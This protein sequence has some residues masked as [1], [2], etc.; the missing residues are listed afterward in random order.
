M[1]TRSIAL[2]VIGT[3]LFS[4][5]SAA[6]VAW[7]LARPA[8]RVAVE[9]AE[10]AG[11]IDG[12]AWGD[13]VARI[14]ALEARGAPLRAAPVEPV[15]AAAPESERV[16]YRADD[17]PDESLEARLRRLERIEA[18]RQE[19]REVERAEDEARDAERRERELERAREA[20]ALILDPLSAD[21]LKVQA[22]LELRRADDGWND[23]IVAEMI[24][25]GTTATD[26]ELREEI[27]AGAD[28]RNRDTALVAPM[29]HALAS[30]PAAGVREEAADSLG[31]YLDEPG[32]RAAL[33]VAAESD[34]DQ[35]VREE[36][37][38]S[39]YGRR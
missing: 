23:D 24:R 15:R 30:D 1:N 35:D 39:L 22:W 31:N 4:S 20:Q 10:P 3:W 26:A 5:A 37:Y 38:D 9:V 19:A 18:E 28:A 27:W 36:A 6:A 13:L 11:A 7:L 14:E 17:A 25:S 32:V 16:A 33:Q 12:A 34:P 8:P 29:L 2:L 21:P